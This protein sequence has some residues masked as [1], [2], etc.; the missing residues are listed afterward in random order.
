VA[1]I[2]KFCRWRKAAFA[3]PLHSMSLEGVLP[4]PKLNAARVLGVWDSNP[5]NHGNGDQ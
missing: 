4:D 2:S 3:A 5:G 1:G